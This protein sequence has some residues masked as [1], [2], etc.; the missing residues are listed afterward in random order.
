MSVYVKTL[1]AARKHRGKPTQGIQKQW[2]RRKIYSSGNWSGFWACNVGQCLR[3][4]D[5]AGSFLQRP[6][7]DRSL[8]PRFADSLCDGR[9]Q[10]RLLANSAG[11]PSLS[12]GCSRPSQRLSAK[13]VERYTC[14]YSGATKRRWVLGE[15]TLERPSARRRESNR[16]GTNCGESWEAS[17]ICLRSLPL[18]RIEL[19]SCPPLARH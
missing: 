9:E 19:T 10:P 6:R 13:R 2:Q 3:A 16:A 1:G 7:K 8:H 12:R 17:G 5:S 11:F 14:I 4:Q 15:A 18:I